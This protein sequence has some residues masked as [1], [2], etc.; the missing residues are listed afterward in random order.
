MGKTHCWFGWV[1]KLFTSHEAKAK[2]PKNWRWPFGRSKCKQYPAI[3]APNRTLTEATAE[4]RKHALAVAAAT[5]AA[6]EAAVAAAQAAAE[7]VW[8]TSASHSW[9]YQK[10]D[11]ILAAIKIQSAYRAHLARKA[12]RAL[13]GLVR[14]QS[15]VRGRAVRRQLINTLKQF[16][17]NGRR[18]V[19]VHEGSTPTAY[20]RCKTGQKKQFLGPKKQ[21]TLESCS[22]GNWDCSLHLKEDIE[23]EM[24][25]KQEAIIKRE[26]MEKYS[27]SH[28]ERRNP[29]MVEESVLNKDFGRGSCRLEQLVGKET[30]NTEGLQTLKSAI[31]ST[32][33]SK[34]LYG[35]RVTLKNTRKE[36]L[37][38]GLNS[39]ASYQRRSIFHVK[40][41]PAGDDSSMPNS[42]AF[43]T[44]MVVTESAKEK[45][46]SM[47]T[48]R[49][50]AGFP[51]ISPKHSAEHKRGVSLW[52]SYD[53]ATMKT[54]GNSVVSQQ[55]IW[56][57]DVMFQVEVAG[58]QDVDV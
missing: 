31:P 57:K 9:H 4:Q 56:E 50:R 16:P 55:G 12:L 28:R 10:G 25:R 44:N 33:I 48:P 45:A 47:S 39:Q 43:S 22:Q 24:L 5:A 46:R 35:T 54:N 49:Q 20:G 6:A 51:D 15:I 2:K 21:F 53:G 7:V 23:A 1:K 26:R 11:P 37:Q 8:L 18:E 58:P 42:P 38:E 13:K 29:H 19:D 27:F 14:L 3:D 32:L 40:Q 36:D 34:E 52:S 30:C 41:N 17:S